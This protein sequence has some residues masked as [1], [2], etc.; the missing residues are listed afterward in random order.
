MHVVRRREVFFSPMCAPTVLRL[1]HS[2][3]GGRLP[4]A[5]SCLI[6]SA[7]LVRLRGC[8]NGVRLEPGGSVRAA[9]DLTARPQSVH[10]PS[11]IRPPPIPL[12]RRRKTVHNEPPPTVSR[13]SPTALCV[14]R[15]GK[16]GGRPPPAIRWQMPRRGYLL[17]KAIARYTISAT[18][19]KL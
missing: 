15:G 5:N 6:I 16:Y 12:H 3:I 7:T 1:P 2:P 11:A 9:L 14:C 4:I 19:M 10:K 18:M 13:P 17:S 8:L